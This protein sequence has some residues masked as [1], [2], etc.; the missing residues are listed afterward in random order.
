ML[1]GSVLDCVTVY[2][3]ESSLLPPSLSWYKY[4][5]NGLSSK[6]KFKNNFFSQHIFFM[7]FHYVSLS[8]ER[9]SCVGQGWGAKRHI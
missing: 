1:R 8:K 7:D 4:R 5:D 3:K 9:R 2:K 6:K